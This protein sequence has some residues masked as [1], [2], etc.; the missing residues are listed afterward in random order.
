M[1]G[2][3]PLMLAAEN[4]HFDLA[5]ELLDR[6]ADPN[7][8]RTGYSVLHA[9]TWIRKPDIGESA[10]GDPARAALVYAIVN[11]LFAS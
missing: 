6:G 4:G 2:T 10:S 7:D 5:I 11:S 1:S 9:L 8:V 3:S